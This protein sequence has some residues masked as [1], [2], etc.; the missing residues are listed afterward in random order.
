MVVAPA[1]LTRLADQ[2]TGHLL[3]PSDPEYVSCRL[4]FLAVGDERLPQAVVRAAGTA[5]ISAALAFARTHG[6]DV[7]LRSGGHS[8]ADRSSTTGLLLDLGA[9]R[10]LRR[11][12][13][14]VTAGPGLRM[15]ELRRQLAVDDRTVS[16]GWCPD[17]GLG[18]A[19]LGGGY[20]SLSR[21]YGLGSDHLVAAEVVLADGR[22]LWCDAEREPEL[23]WTLRGAGGGLLGA[24]TSFVLRTRPAVPAT[25]FECRWPVRHAADII[26]TW[27]SWAPEAPDE[28]NAEVGLIGPYDPAEEPWVAVFG[29]SVGAGTAFLDRFAPEPEQVA[30]RDLPASVAAAVSYPEL[31]EDLEVT[32]PPWGTSPGRR[33]ARSEFFDA[34]LTPAVVA[35][36]IGH[37]TTGRVTGQARELEF[38]PWGGAYG[39]VAPQATAFVHRRAR[40]ILKHTGYTIRRSTPD[41][42]QETQRWVDRSWAITH[43]LGS[44]RIYPNYPEPGRSPLDAA[45]HGGN[46]DRVRR[47]VA[48]YDPDAVFTA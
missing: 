36:L 5:D 8:F 4:P 14:L 41:V 46:V 28:I 35:A 15:H 10:E 45:Y 21:L 3:T 6:L 9:L 7:A 37:L 30:I 12:G 20:G 11:D 31:P 29:V 32:G 13:D 22:I 47:A 24:V 38:I 18:G 17:V 40:F 43:P 39:R 19:V 1:P 48:R 44:G 2:L 16:C 27:L 34:T 33:L 25:F 23:F 26:G 42:R